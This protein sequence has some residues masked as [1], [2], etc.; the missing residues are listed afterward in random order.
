MSSFTFL[1]TA[2]MH[3][4][5]PLRGLARY[6]G[7]PV[8]RIREASRRAFDR[9]VQ[10]A[11][12]EGV[13]FVVI[14]GDLFFLRENLEPDPQSGWPFHPPGRFYNILELWQSM[15]DVIRRADYIL[16]THDPI[17]LEQ[18]IYP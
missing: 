1:H 14:A 6:D 16:V 15:E 11:V 5:S 13:A 9:L 10:A 8:H 3:L 2:D 7:A 12:S 17:H 18:E 4:D